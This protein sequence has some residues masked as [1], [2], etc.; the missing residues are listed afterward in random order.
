[1]P[2]KAATAA[3]FGSALPY[4]GSILLV[5][6]IGR[7]ERQQGIRVAAKSRSSQRPDRF[8]NVDRC[9]NSPAPDN[10][11]SKDL[12]STHCVPSGGPGLGM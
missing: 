12:W 7:P 10:S 6:G 8:S 11:Q 9:H 2:A 3:S 4:C 1:M 5:L